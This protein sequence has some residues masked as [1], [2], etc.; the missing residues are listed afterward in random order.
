MSRCILLVLLLPGFVF[1]Q[2]MDQTPPRV[3]VPDKLSGWW[4]MMASSVEAD[5]PNMGRNLNVPGC[6]TVSFVIEKDGSTS[7][8][9]VQKVV[10]TG[11]LGKVGASVAHGLHFEPTAFNAGRERV[12]SWL[13]FPFNL[14]SDAAARSAVMRQCAI[15]H[16]EWKDR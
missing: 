2:S 11:D 6:A 12:F 13:I 4:Q 5:V 3:V 10:P 1:A 9:K 14:P 7:T 15:D 8:V 16:L